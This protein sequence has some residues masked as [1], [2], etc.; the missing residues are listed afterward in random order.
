[1]RILFVLPRYHPN[2]YF[3]TEALHEAGHET[4]YLVHKKN[5][6]HEAYDHAEPIAVPHHPAPRLLRWLI[7]AYLKLTAG[8]VRPNVVAW[9]SYRSLKAMVDEFAPELIVVREAT[10]PLSLATLLIAKRKRVPTMLYTQYPLE[11]RDPLSVRVLRACGLIPH[12]RITPTKTPKA[13]TRL[14]RPGAHYVPLVT[15]FPFDIDTKQYNQAGVLNILSVAK[16]ASK[17][18]NHLLLLEAVAALSA[19]RPMHLTLVGGSAEL[20]PDYYRQIEATVAKLGLSATV[21]LKTIVPFN[22]M[23]TLYQQAD[24]FV[25]PSVREP[26]AISPIEAMNFGAPV[27]LTNSNGAQHA[28]ETGVNGFVVAAN[29]QLALT[30]ALAAI[31]K[32]TGTIALMGRA[33]YQHQQAHFTKA[34]FLSHWN[35]AVAAAQADH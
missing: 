10:L 9:P 14:A 35:T 20:E 19:K 23:R 11:A 13:D 4:R 6:A 8:K 30:E 5:P 25:L 27:I 12:V 3:W 28:V 26:F 22:E 16:F 32:D 29:D 18:K 15:D 7:A 1:M 17:R 2:Q 21:T 24:V 31:T 34:V 33:A